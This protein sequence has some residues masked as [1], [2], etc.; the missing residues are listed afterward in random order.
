MASTG[1]ALKPRPLSP[2]LGIYR[3]TLTMM[4][5]ITHRITGVGLYIGVILLAW[6]LL[7]LAGDARTF[8]AF[9]AFIHSFIGQLLLFGFTWALFHHLLG[10]LRHFL[11]DTGI[12]FQ[13]PLREQLAKA[14]LIGGVALAVIAWIIGYAV[15]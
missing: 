5:S 6:F 10:G 14:N 2:H 12:G 7:A 3:R 15:R 13:A 11:W 9:S 8:A 4:M 1:T